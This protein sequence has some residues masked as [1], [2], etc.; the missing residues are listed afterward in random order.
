MS[1]HPQTDQGS[2]AIF[3]Q[4]QSCGTLGRSAVRPHTYVFGYH[5]TT[6]ATHAVSLTM[7]V[8]ADQYGYRKAFIRFF[9]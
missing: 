9:R 4:G 6:P 2:L 5:P 1:K 8:M 7:P 3:V